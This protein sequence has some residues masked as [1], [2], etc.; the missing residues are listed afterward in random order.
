M[1]EV[2]VTKLGVVLYETAQAPTTATWKLTGGAYPKNA[3]LSPG[4][5]WERVGVEGGPIAFAPPRNVELKITSGAPYTLRYA[6]ANGEMLT[7]KVDGGTLVEWREALRRA[8]EAAKNAQTPADDGDGRRRP[9][10]IER[11]FSIPLP[12]R[13]FDGVSAESPLRTRV[14]R[15][16]Q[17]EA[18]PIGEFASAA[19]WHATLA[20]HTEEY[21]RA[22]VRLLR[23]TTRRG[24]D[25]APGQ[26]PLGVYAGDYS[27]LEHASS[28]AAEIAETLPPFSD[29]VDRPSVDAARHV[30]LS[31][32]HRVPGEL[33]REQIST[34]K[35]AGE[36]TALCDALKQFS[37][38]LGY[39]DAD[40][41]LAEEEVVGTEDEQALTQ[42]R[43]LDFWVRTAYDV[44]MG[45][46]TG[47]PSIEYGGAKVRLLAQLD[48]A[49]NAAR[50]LSDVWARALDF[51]GADQEREEIEVGDPPRTI[52]IQRYVEWVESD[53]VAIKSDVEAG[54]RPA[55]RASIGLLEIQADA[56][57]ALLEQA[58]DD[59]APTTLAHPIVL[60]VL[61]TLHAHLDRAVEAAH[62]AVDPSSPDQPE[63]DR[64]G[65]SNVR[66]ATAD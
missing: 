37:V 5:G 51:T 64:Y 40:M 24:Y 52:T 59:D 19:E 53:A 27:L 49:S 44:M 54:G 36:A 31:R 34:L 25:Q 11:L 58:T 12:T 8:R 21:E 66:A 32:I 30:L 55:I 47:Q 17:N 42:F 48:G 63:P 38:V 23:W 7:A 16:I 15:M 41:N 3:P 26:Q 1:A 18:G 35:L 10:A 22:G 39:T 20:R 62:D 4:P 65:R 61:E 13:S 43:V 9:D 6:D 56:A 57:E 2:L 46:V 50:R 14:R 60:A 29:T 33:A 28:V 45:L